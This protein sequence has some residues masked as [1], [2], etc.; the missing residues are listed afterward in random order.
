MPSSGQAFLRSSIFSL[1]YWWVS[2][3][4]LH[5]LQS[6]RCQPTWSQA[7]Y[8]SA[9]STRPTSLSLLRDGWPVKWGLP[10]L[11]IKADLPFVPVLEPGHQS[12]LA[13]AE[14]VSNI[15]AS[16]L[17]CLAKSWSPS[18]AAISTTDSAL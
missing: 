16:N 8:C 18:T 5:W 9:A 4:H 15:L 10:P 14:K 12:A 6:C 3:C 17:L 1:G 7:A 2:A 13:L 11:R